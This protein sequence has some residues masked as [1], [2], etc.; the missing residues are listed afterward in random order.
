MSI[1]ESLIYSFFASSTQLLHKN[2]LHE[3]KG[4]LHELNLLD[5]NCILDRAVKK[6]QIGGSRFK[7]KTVGIPCVEDNNTRE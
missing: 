2:L 5:Y 6:G 1:H 3:K 7:E 4:V